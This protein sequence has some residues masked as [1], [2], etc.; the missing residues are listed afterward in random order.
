M[1]T[2]TYS[3]LLTDPRWQ[4]KRLEIME[5]DGFVCKK[6]EHGDITLNVHHIEYKKGLLPWEYPSNS[7]ITLCKYCHL[8]I[9]ELKKRNDKTPFNEISI[10]HIM[11]DTRTIRVVFVVHGHVCSLKH[12]YKDKEV[13]HFPFGGK[14]NRIISEMFKKASEWIPVDKRADNSDVFGVMEQYV[15]PEKGVFE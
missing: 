1:E 8:E 3:E 6:C 7:L 5:R 14:K 2:K 4:K 11:N 9:E 12:Y 15:K 10:Y 13:D